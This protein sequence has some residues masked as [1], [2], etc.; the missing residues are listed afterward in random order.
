MIIKDTYI[1][2][3]WV[4]QASVRNAQIK[5][6]AE[7][8]AT[9]ILEL[10]LAQKTIDG[11]TPFTVGYK[12]VTLSFILQSLEEGRK[13]LNQIEKERKEEEKDDTDRK[14]VRI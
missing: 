3:Q 1:S 10:T 7:W 6:K 11:A 8:V 12:N 14:G 5:H 9:P 4:I 2:P 13:Y